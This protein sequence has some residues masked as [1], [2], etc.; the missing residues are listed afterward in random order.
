MRSY[1][2]QQRRDSSYEIKKREQLRAKANPGPP[3][4][5][6]PY[7]R[8]LEICYHALIDIDVSYQ[9]S[10]ISLSGLPWYAVCPFGPLC[11]SD[12]GSRKLTPGRRPGM[13]ADRLG[14]P[15]SGQCS[16]HGSRLVSK[17]PHTQAVSRHSFG[18]L[19]TPARDG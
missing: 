7:P 10:C 8:D 19:R 12:F 15:M 18:A 4:P 13:R 11:A 17:T 16:D 14:L 5:D 9:K 1:M 6:Y 3:K 2:N